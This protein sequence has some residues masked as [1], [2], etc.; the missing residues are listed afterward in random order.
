MVVTVA[1]TGVNPPKKNIISFIPDRMI[2]LSH[3]VRFES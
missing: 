3:P 1:D 2:Q